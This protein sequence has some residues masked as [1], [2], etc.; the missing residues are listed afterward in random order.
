MAGSK[1]SLHARMQASNERGQFTA[2]TES[3]QHCTRAPKVLNLV[4]SDSDSEVALAATEKR[5][6]AAAAGKKKGAE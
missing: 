6:A 3:V 1:H 5:A 2:A 4:D